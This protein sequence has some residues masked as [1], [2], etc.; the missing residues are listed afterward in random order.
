MSDKQSPVEIPA[1]SPQG[2]SMRD[3]W[4]VGVWHTYL[5]VNRMVKPSVGRENLDMW[6]K[7]AVKAIVFVDKT[8]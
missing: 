1:V 4:L 5:L 6:V 2:I 8:G 3:V 7:Y